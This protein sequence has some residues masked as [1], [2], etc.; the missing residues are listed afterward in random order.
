MGNIAFF[1]AYTNIIPFADHNQYP[2]NAFSSKQGYSAIGIYATN[3]NNRIDTSS[4]II[5]YPQR[6]LIHTKYTKYVHNEELPNGE[7]VI[8]AIATYTGFNQEDSIIVNKNSI[9]RGM[10]NITKFKA[11]INEDFPA[12]GLPITENFGTR[13]STDSF[14]GKSLTNSSNNS[15]EP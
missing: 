15:P 5:H 11:L 9:E 12:F 7:N 6:A 10:F 3:F 8:V 13:S 1:C 14:S 2:R 4:Y